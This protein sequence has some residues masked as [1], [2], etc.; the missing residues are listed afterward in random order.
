MRTPPPLLLPTTTALTP[1]ATMT[2]TKEALTTTTTAWPKR[3]R[4]KGR[5]CQGKVGKEFW[6]QKING[7]ELIDLDT[8][9]KKKSRA[10]TA[11]YSTEKRGCYTI[12]PYT[13][14]KKNKI[15]VVLHEGGM[16]PKDAQPQ[17]SLLPLGKTLSVQ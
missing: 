7:G 12:N 16:P 10:A 11:R 8:P 5:C 6:W 1:P 4:K 14:R 9:P 3:R 13:H 17:V 2:T 15:N